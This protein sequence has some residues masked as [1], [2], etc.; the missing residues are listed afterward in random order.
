VKKLFIAL[1]AVLVWTAIPAVSAH[2]VSVGQ[3]CPKTTLGT[4]VSIR[5]NKKPLIVVCR[6]KAGRKKWI[7]A[8]VQT[9]V[10]TTT[11]TS[12]TSTT[13]TTTPVTAAFTDEASQTEP[14]LRTFTVTGKEPRTYYL[15]VS[16]NYSKETPAPLILA[17]H[18][19]TTNAKE[20]LRSTSILE[21]VNDMGFVLA[22]INGAVHEFSSWNAGTCCTPATDFKED[23]V[24][25]SSLII[26]SLSST[27]SIDPNRIW[28]IGH[29]NGGMMAYRLACDLSDKISGVAIVGGA[30]MDDS[31]TPEKPVS[32]MHIHG[33]LD[34]TIPFTGGGKF[35]VPDIQTSVIKPNANFS[36]DIAPNE[37]MP[38]VG[39]NQVAWNCEQGAQTKLMNYLDNG[40]EWH[41]EYTKAIL[42]FL[43]AHPRK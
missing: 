34:E 42:R 6:K 28:A 24:E 32:I 14:T 31:C 18:S 26:D 39:V 27:Y 17:F 3:A 37:I 30:L 15:N 43:F 8:A 40:H 35:D 25:L 33:D 36:C 4:R 10:T 2:A 16:A 1:S 9:L 12:T 11:S 21:F 38:I 22:T 41:L 13:S 7:R 20:L 29:S 23:D 5:V 19:R